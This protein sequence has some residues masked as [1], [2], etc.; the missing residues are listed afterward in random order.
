[1]PTARGASDLAPRTDLATETDELGL[2]TASVLATFN[3][4]FNLHDVDAV[5]AVMTEDCVFESTAPPDGVRFEGQ[6]AVRTAWTDFFAASQDAAFEVEEEIICRDRAIVRWRYAWVDG[7]VRGVD[8]FTIRD[9]LVA[10]KLCY[11]KG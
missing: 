1:M 9:G 6:A 10:A 2:I 8:V 3:A 11:V 4:A 7:H 5:M